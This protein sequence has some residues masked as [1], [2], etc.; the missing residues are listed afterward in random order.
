MKKNLFIL[1]LF[2][3]FNVFSQAYTPLL[4]E[5]NKWWGSYSEGYCPSCNPQ[6]KAYYVFINGETT[7]NGQ[8]YKKI[9]S[10]FY[11]NDTM[12]PTGAAGQYTNNPDV[13]ECLMRE[14]LV[15]KKVYFINANT[16]TEKIL[17]DFSAQIGD[18]VEANWPIYQETGTMTVDKIVYGS[19]FGKSNVKTFDLAYGNIYEGIGSQSGLFVRPSGR[20]FELGY[21]WL[22][23]FEDTS[24]KS[25]VS[26]F[27]PLATSESSIEKN[28][29]LYYSK[30]N[31]D[32]KILGNPSQDYKISF[33]EST[34]RLVEEVNAKGKQNYSLR[35]AVKNK[36][37]FYTI[38]SQGNV[39]KGKIL[40]Q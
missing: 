10:N 34:G 8:V 9:Y 17:Y 5:G 22:G 30:E 38:T 11:F 1:L 40:I 24:G 33:Y 18:V 14:D 23:C 32:F 29:T 27:V 25:C 37:L 12:T 3:F 36:I 26:E 19:V 2:A 21:F 16:N 31:Q 39:W 35:N 7:V 13:F 15:A 28:L 4:K 20:R 6:Y